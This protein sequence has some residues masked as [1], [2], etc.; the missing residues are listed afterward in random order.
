MLATL[1]AA[2]DY[3]TFTGGDGVDAA[4]A[5][6]SPFAN[7]NSATFIASGTHT[8]VTV[9]F[10]LKTPGGTWLNVGT[11]NGITM[12]VD[13]AAALT[14]ASNGSGV[15]NVRFPKGTFIDSKVTLE[16]ISTGDL[17]VE[18][19]AGVADPSDVPPMR[20]VSV[21]STPQTI[22]SADAAA[23]AVGPNGAT[24]PVFSVNAATA[25]A[26]TGLKVTGAAAAGGVALVVTSSGTNEALTIN[27]KGSGTIGIGTV[28]TGAITLGAATGVT[29]A[30]TITSTSASGLA[31]GANGATNP[32]LKVNANTASVATGLHITG[33]AAAGGLA[34]AVISSGTNESLT[35][36]AKGSGTITIGGT[37]TGNVNLGGGGGRVVLPGT[38]TAGGLLTCALQVATSGPLIY[39]GSGAP[40]ISAAVKGSLYM[41]T[42][43]SSTSTRVYVATDTAG[44]WA[45][46]TTAS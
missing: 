27:A 3:A 17:D 23:L 31:V 35:V 40:S 12:A 44:G 1:D 33:A 42:D 26:A 39:S 43:G 6:T 7:F 15:W 2:N 25:S 36:D 13:P 20:Q 24:N 10:W 5:G 45:A 38:L 11:V 9:K 34:V 16:G 29:G 18:L 41:R 4:V 8:G 22:T 37:S 14:I 21:T 46:I 30:L 32:V 28:S 19:L